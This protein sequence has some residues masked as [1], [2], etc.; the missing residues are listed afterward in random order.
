MSD[1]K[2]NGRGELRR[3]DEELVHDL[4][5]SVD[6]SRKIHSR[7]HD[8]SLQR[9]HLWWDVLFFERPRRRGLSA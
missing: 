9:A 7:L 6:R 4:S 5:R 2:E 3:G 8:V 1:L